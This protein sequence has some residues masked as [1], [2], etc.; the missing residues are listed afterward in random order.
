MKILTFPK[1]HIDNQY[2]LSFKYDSH[3]SLQFYEVLYKVAT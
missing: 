1:R 2:D 3:E